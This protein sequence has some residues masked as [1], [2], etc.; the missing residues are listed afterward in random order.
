M[1]NVVGPDGSVVKVSA[2]FIA[3]D[4]RIVIC[5]VFLVGGVVDVVVDVVVF[6]VDSVSGGVGLVVVDAASVDLPAGWVTRVVTAK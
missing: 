5:V 1:F 6:L 3:V 4:V 2:V